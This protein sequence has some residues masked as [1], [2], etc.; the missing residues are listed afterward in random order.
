MKVLLIDSEQDALDVL[1]L[2][3]SQIEN[4]EVVGTYTDPQLAF[5]TLEHTS[6][7]V[8][9]LDI[10]MGK[11]DGLQFADVVMSEFSHLSL[12]FVTDRPEFA[13]EAFEVNASDYLLKPLDRN[14]LTRTIGN[15]REKYEKQ[16]IEENA[17]IRQRLFVQAMGSFHLLDHE[18]NEVKWRTKKVKEL[19][20]YLWHNK[21]KPIHRTRIIEEL[22]R[23]S[24]EDK[25][26]SIL[27]TTVYQLR[28]ALKKTGIEHPVKLI[29]EQYMLTIAVDSDIEQLNRALQIREATPS[30][31]EET[32][33]LYQGD[34]LEEENYHWLLFE[35][36]RIK[37]AFLQ[38][39]EK[40]IASIQ[41]V[42][43]QHHLFEL[44][45][46]KMIQLEPYNEK[47]SYFLLDHYGK[48]KNMPKMIRLFK[49]FK[50]K[51]IEELGIDI[52]KEV[53]EVYKK[54][55]V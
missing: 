8:V 23:D 51:W 27:H 28:K 11:V 32:I 13:F 45:I 53:E 22:W 4:I 47:Y 26:A 3:L 15:L 39:L 25:A 34:Y 5:D 40:Y 41:K 52:P 35:Q 7:D 46:E 30:S 29:N 17:V 44:C 38:Y 2:L 54:Y 33:N 37:K 16:K 24:Q 48:T 21:D 12:V 43:K 10:Q 18:Q 1:E 36:Q 20:V 50:E 9:F 42:P 14:R 31:I 49:E 6:V 19:F 55:I